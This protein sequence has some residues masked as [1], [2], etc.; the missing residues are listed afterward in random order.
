MPLTGFK[1]AKITDFIK[2]IPFFKCYTFM[3]LSFLIIVC[4]VSAYT[5]YNEFYQL[6]KKSV[7]V[8]QLTKI[9]KPTIVSIYG[10]LS[11]CDASYGFFAPNV[12]SS[13]VIIVENNGKQ[14]R[15]TFKSN[16]ASIRFSSLESR[17]SE[18]FFEN[19]DEEKK[20]N[21]S[22]IN[23]YYNLL[24]KA[25]AVKL[26]NE[27]KL[28]SYSTSVN[29]Q[30]YDF[31]SLASFRKGEKKASLHALYHLNLTPTR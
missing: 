5:N 19:I 23:A 14:Y 26:L 4:S 9:F 21:D 1:P 2:G 29:Y 22:L 20:T 28:K 18:P 10:R 3:H 11:G 24:F 12:R 31:P 13:G 30:L 25:I 6:K 17:I 15:P 27:K 8:D 7:L 16:E